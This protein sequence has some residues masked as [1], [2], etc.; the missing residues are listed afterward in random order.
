VSDLPSPD[1][2]RRALHDE[3][4]SEE[5]LNDLADR[6]EEAGRLGEVLEILE[7]TRDGERLRRI[8]KTAVTRGEV[9]VLAQTERLLRDVAPAESWRAAGEKALT[10]GRFRQARTAFERAG[11]EERAAAAGS[12]IPAPPRTRPGQE[13]RAG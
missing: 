8:R 1:R 10:E 2:K 13:G 6:F 7:R 5:E 9:F 11:D 4:T 12:E 3:R